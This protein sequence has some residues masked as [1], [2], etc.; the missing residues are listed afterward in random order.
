[1]F[2]LILNKF[3]I[4]ISDN[5]CELWIK[6]LTTLLAKPHNMCNADEIRL[7]F[8][9]ILDYTIAFKNEICHS[10]K[11]SKERITILLINNI[12]GA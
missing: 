10:N 11:S 7:F 4:S 2:N 12:M 5:V 9:F 3:S 8:R 1:M 6:E